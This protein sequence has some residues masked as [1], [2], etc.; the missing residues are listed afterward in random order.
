MTEMTVNDQAQTQGERDTMLSD[1]SLRIER[2][3][4]ATPEEVFDAW[5]SPEVLRRWWAAHPQGST[6]VA[7]V[8]LRAGGRYRLSMESPDGTRHTVEAETGSTV[9]ETAIRHGVT[10]IVAECGGACSCAT[11]MVYVDEAWFDRLAPRSGEEEDMLANPV[12]VKDNSLARTSAWANA[13]LD[14]DHNA[15]H[16]QFSG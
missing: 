16:G 6:P 15:K 14:R 5:T 13:L 2:S 1:T 12:V 9:M 10:G 7:E 8:D 4:D 11:C 3:F